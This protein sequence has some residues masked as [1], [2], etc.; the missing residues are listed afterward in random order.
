M[1]RMTGVTIELTD[2]P[3]FVN[4]FENNIRGGVSFVGHRFCEKTDGPQDPRANAY[5]HSFERLLMLLV[6]ANN[7][8]SSAQRKKQY[9]GGL[10]WMTAKELSTKDWSVYDEDSEL[11]YAVEVDLE[12]PEELHMQFS[13]LPLAPEHMDIDE[14]ILSPFCLKVLRELRH[15]NKHN[16]KKLVSTLLPKQRY[17]V[18]A[19]LLALYISLGMVVTRVHRAVEWETSPFLESFI[20][21]CTKKR[22]N[23][24]TEFRKRLFKG[25]KI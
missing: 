8:Y 7:L 1:L 9:I 2:N 13:S 6:D 4:F 24:K 11:D 16:S 15:T 12:V 17:V 10:R 22:S 20:D 25:E 23:A 18:H 5:P 19:A 3:D 21:F 14:T